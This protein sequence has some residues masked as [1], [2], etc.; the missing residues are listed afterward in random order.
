MF[1]LQWRLL[2]L[3]IESVF[4]KPTVSESV[5]EAKAMMGGEGSG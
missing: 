1:G 5:A 4:S 3:K 2:G